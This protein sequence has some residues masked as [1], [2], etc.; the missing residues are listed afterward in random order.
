MEYSLQMHLMELGKFGHIGR[1][2]NEHHMV[3]GLRQS[4]LVV[5]CYIPMFSLDRFMCIVVHI[6]LVMQYAMASVRQFLTEA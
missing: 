3:F 5:Y 1:I 2:L 4:C 6:S